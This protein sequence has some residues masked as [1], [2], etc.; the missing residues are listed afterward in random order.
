MFSAAFPIVGRQPFFEIIKPGGGPGHECLID[1]HGADP[2]ICPRQIK[3]Q[4][5]RIM[6]HVREFAAVGKGEE[7][8]ISHEDARGGSASIFYSN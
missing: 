8:W 1:P 2:L 5:Q 3:A 6:V 4:T 7:V